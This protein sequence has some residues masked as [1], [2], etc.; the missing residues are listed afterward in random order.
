[1]TFSFKSALIA[2]SLS[3]AS[4][5]VGAAGFQLLEVEDA[6]HA[7]LNVGLWYP[8]NRAAPAEPNTE[9]ELPVALN[10]PMGVTNGG[11]IVI[12]HGFGGWYGG[13][14]DTA[15][16]L[17]DAGFLVAAPTHNGNTWSDMSSSIDQWALDRPRHVSRVMDYMLESTQFNPYIDEEKIGVYG[18]SAGGF[19]A[20]GLIGGVPDFDQMTS[21][22]AHQ[23]QEYVCS[24]GMIDDILKAN[25]GALARSAWGADERVSAAAIAA[26]GLGFAYTAS[27]LAS[28]SADVQLWS[29]ELDNSVPTETNA[30]WLADQ[31][32]VEPETHWIEKAN[33]FAFM[34]VACRDAFKQADPQEYAVVCSDADGFD[35]YGFH[36]HLH[37]EM[38]RF[39][40]ESFSQSAVQQ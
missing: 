7:R 39:F 32:P 12:S 8:S 1:M 37:V 21:H 38:I 4:L 18:F 34:T 31:L 36:E 35:R 15:I 13:H 19:T 28:V 10:A 5:N 17:A 33:H 11:L 14:A 2:G 9:F 3:V 20:L 16:A 24:E 6:G 25:M 29:G 27:S 30:G 22:C 23:P 26:P 40:N